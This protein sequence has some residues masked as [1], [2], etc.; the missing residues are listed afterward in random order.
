[1]TAWLT[2]FPAYAFLLCVPSGRENEVL[3]AF[4]ARGLEAA[5]V[6]MIDDT[7]LLSLTSGGRQ[8]TV[9]DLAA[10]GVTGLQH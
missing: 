2:C 10:T 5:V 3:A 6:G 9:L 4:H 7:G 1:M 8:A